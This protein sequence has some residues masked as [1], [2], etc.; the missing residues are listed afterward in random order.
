[1][2]PLKPL[3]AL[4]RF[5]RGLAT[6]LGTLGTDLIEIS[7]PQRCPGCGVPAGPERLLCPQC[8]RAIPRAGVTVCVRCLSRG[9]AGDACTRHP[10]F[11][12][13]AAWVYD[14]AAALVVGALKFEG[15]TALAPV[16][17]A[18][19]AAWVPPGPRVDLVTP[20]PLHPA[21]CRERGYNQSRL[22]A[23]EL[24]IRIEAPFVDGLLARRR[25]TRAQTGLPAAERRENVSG[26]FEVVKPH[27]VRG[28]C[29]L[30][31]DDVVTTG[32]TLA[33]CLE[34]LEA[35]GAGARAAVLAWA[36]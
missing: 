27:A 28:R 31:V 10:G 15:R 19:M 1:V 16:L 9:R 26:A 34:A 13:G 24:A 12:A 23:E 11:R 8:W 21:R 4:H 7:F 6:G 25:A 33:A 20:V 29:V 36:A 3:H 32:A 5:A 22:L 30:L 18:E 2:A 35:A 17:A 14:E